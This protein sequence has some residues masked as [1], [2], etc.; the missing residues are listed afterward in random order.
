MHYAVSGV[1]SRAE[2]EERAIFS[3]LGSGCVDYALW[4]PR[5]DR[6][7]VVL[8]DLRVRKA[9]ADRVAED[10]LGDQSQLA[11]D[12]LVVLDGLFLAPILGRRRFSS[13]MAI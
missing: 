4:L 12:R 7:F 13:L 10:L 6:G 1:A 11:V 8:D 5:S 3:T 2:C 9:R